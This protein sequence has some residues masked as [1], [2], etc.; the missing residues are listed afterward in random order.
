VDK[1]RRRRRAGKKQKNFVRWQPALP[2]SAR[3][4]TKVF[5]LLFFQK[6]R[7][8]LLLAFFGFSSEWCK[9]KTFVTWRRVVACGGCGRV[10]FWLF[11][12]GAFA[13]VC[14]IEE[15]CSWPPLAV[16]PCGGGGMR[17]A[18]PPY[19]SST[20][21]GC[22]PFLPSRGRRLIRRKKVDFREKALDAI[23]VIN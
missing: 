17:F 20:R 16:W 22:V 14:S 18:F 6:R 15:D 7:L 10:W 21:G 12:R 9:A 19:G 5:L 13:V 3:H 2:A 1:R 4:V 23:L 8:L 11:R